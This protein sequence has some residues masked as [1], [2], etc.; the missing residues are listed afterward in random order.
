MRLTPSYVTY[1]IK[2]FITK[3]IS[4]S[5]VWCSSGRG[6]FFRCI[7]RKKV[8]LFNGLFSQRKAKSFQSLSWFLEPVQQFDCN[9]YAAWINYRVAMLVPDIVII[10]SIFTAEIYKMSNLVFRQMQTYQTHWQLICPILCELNWTDYERHHRTDIYST[11]A[12]KG[13]SLVIRT[14]RNSVY[15]FK[16][17]GHLTSSFIVTDKTTRSCTVGCPTSWKPKW[18]LCELCLLLGQLNR[19]LT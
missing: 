9:L 7:K 1:M 4:I 10:W 15:Q 6:Y 19:L 2:T 18:S 11:A 5:T 13:H 16:H 17:E 8:N 12:W 3:G 14:R